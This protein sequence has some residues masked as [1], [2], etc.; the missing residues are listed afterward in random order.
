MS[1]PKYW[2]VTCSK[3][4]NRYDLRWWSIFRKLKSVTEH[5]DG[6]RKYHKNH[7]CDA[8]VHLIRR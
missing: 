2:I 5:I 4:G 7:K 6:C 1:I 8:K 3:F